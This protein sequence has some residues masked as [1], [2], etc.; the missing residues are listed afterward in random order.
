MKKEK[1]SDENI[2]SNY[3]FK[4]VDDPASKDY[5]ANRPT[6]DDLELKSHLTNEDHQVIPDDDYE[7]LQDLALDEDEKFPWIQLNM[8]EIQTLTK[9]QVHR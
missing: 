4:Q 6:T 9:I 8:N 2:H 5:H 1:N 7:L 3:L